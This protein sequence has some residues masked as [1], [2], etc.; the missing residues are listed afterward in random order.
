MPEKYIGICVDGTK[1]TMVS[2]LDAMATSYSTVDLGDATE[3]IKA[4][5]KN[6]KNKKKSHPI[7]VAVSAQT[8][9]LKS[10]DVTAKATKTYEDFQELLYAA[11]PVAR[12]ST[13]VAGIIHNPEDLIGD[14]VCSGAAASIPTSVVS[15]VY[16]AMGSFPCEVVSTPLVLS[17]YDGV[18][19]GIQQNIAS[20]SLVTKGKIV[21]YRQLRLGGLESIVSLLLGSSTEVKAVQTRVDQALITVNST[22]TQAS[23]EVSRYMRMLVNEL[24]QTIEFWRRQGETIENEGMILVYGPGA[25]SAILDN[26]LNESS[27][28]RA[29][30]SS[31]DRLLVHLNAS[32][33]L[34]SYVAFLAATSIGKN[35]PHISYTNPDA[36]QL[37][38]KKLKKIKTISIVLGALAAVTAL[39]LLVVKPII[40]TKSRESTAKK[41]LELV[42]SNFAPLRDM[43]VLSEEYIARSTVRDEVVNGEPNWY[44]IYTEIASS[45]PSSANVS[46]VV[47]SVSNGVVSVGMSASLQGGKYE[48]IS[49]WLTRLKQVKGVTSAWT[50]GF[51]EREGKV[52]VD[53]TVTFDSKM[54]TDEEEA[55]Q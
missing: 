50:R 49:A 4:L 26:A 48:D 8:T 20:V 11:L 10:L 44:Y 34:D 14:T 27:F 38:V 33:R 29:V 40:E 16:K 13:S 17:L 15:Q 2:T 31:I 3:S 18:W 5:L 6:T 42:E 45:T 24:S 30:C 37:R 46:Q 23:T 25:N 52:A 36:A 32:Q 9:I 43:Y 35:M 51:N 22:D 7:R 21:A 47:S 41:N 53:I 12:D 28:V 54:V 19:L 55:T 39:G 1:A